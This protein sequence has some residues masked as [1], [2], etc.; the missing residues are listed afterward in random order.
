[1]RLACI[2]TFLAL[3]SPAAFA[4]VELLP[5]SS[6][7]SAGYLREFAPIRVRVTDGAGVPVAQARVRFYLATYG[8]ATVLEPVVLTGC[9]RDL[10]LQCEVLADNQGIAQL[11]TMRGVWP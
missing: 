2:L 1:M 5:G 11:H 4:G 8:F 6:P 10:G 7:Q 3:L 9:V